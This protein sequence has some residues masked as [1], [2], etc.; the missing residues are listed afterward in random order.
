MISRPANVA[1]RRAR[2]RLGGSQIVVGIAGA[3]LTT[4]VFF[5]IS[6]DWVAPYDP[7]KQNLI[8]ALQGPSAAHWLGTDDLGRD[9]LS[10]LLYGCRIAIVAAAEATTLAVV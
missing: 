9:V 1:S 10:R 5:A 6:A 2:R 3:V 7:L 4:L 8:E